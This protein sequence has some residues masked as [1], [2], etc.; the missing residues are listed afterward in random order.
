MYSAWGRNTYSYPI[1]C[2]NCGHQE[3]IPIRKGTLKGSA[4]RTY[5]CPTCGNYTCVDMWKRYGFKV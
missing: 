3:E 5:K 2:T 4:I 1:V